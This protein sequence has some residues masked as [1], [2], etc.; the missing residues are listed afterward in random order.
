LVRQA[1]AFQQV[2]LQ[3]TPV[4]IPD[5]RDDT[6]LAH[7]FRENV[8]D[9]LETAFAYVHSWLGVP[10]TI[11]EQVIGM[12]GLHH[13]QPNYYT[14]RHAKL[15]SAFANHAAI[16]IENARLYEQA[17]ELATLRE[18]QRLAHDLHDAVSQSLFSASL[19]AEVL[20]R[21][22]ERHPEEGRLCLTELHRLTRSA[23]AEMRTLLLELRPAALVETA[24]G[25]LLNQLAEAIA[26]RAMLSVTMVIEAHDPLPPEVQ[27]ALYRI[28]QEALNNVAKHAG[29]SRV[30]VKLRPVPSLVVGGEPKSSLELGI[31]DDGCGFNF[32]RVSPICLGLSI[33][34]ERAETIGATLKIESQLGQGTQVIVI[35]PG[36]TEAVP[37]AHLASGL[38]ELI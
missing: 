21:L 6:P 9:R 34:R 37:L 32:D 10:L 30:E 38:A 13:D 29:A 26:S 31:G 14:S 17:Q 3:Q 2:I 25:D 23:L 28:A 36:V 19:S 27:L 16:A 4:I 12:L 35:W 15:A 7:L 22:W 24:L 8:G 11:K 5:V 33:M 1:G 20:P 18:R